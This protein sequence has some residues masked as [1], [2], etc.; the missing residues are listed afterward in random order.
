MKAYAAILS[1]RFR[2]LVQYR[3]A[4]LAG[5]VTQVFWGLIRIAAFSAFFASTTKTQPLSFEEIVTYTWLGQCTLRL[6][7]FGPDG[8][9]RNLIRTGGVAYE[10]VRPLD[11]YGLWYMRALAQMAAPALL[12]G[13][14]MAVIAGAFF[15][16]S[17]PASP[18]AALL[19]ALSIACS[20]LLSAAI[21][22]LLSISLLWT[23]AGDGVSRMTIFTAWSFSGIVLPVQFFSEW[24]QPLINFLPFRG[25]IDTPSRLYMGQLSGEQALLAIGHQLAWIVVLA[26]AGKL[27]LAG[28]TRRIVVQGG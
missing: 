22:V 17:A 13:I 12:R 23:I 9:V 15:S 21:T 24:M 5:L 25:I 16:M 27:I 6:L 2:T 10:L 3:A 28:S 26:A 4:A 11:L 8:D 14:P 19:W 7:P 1:A 18:E 20:V